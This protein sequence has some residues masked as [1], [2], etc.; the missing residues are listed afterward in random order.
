MA[1]IRLA[2]NNCDFA[3]RK[4]LATIGKGRKVATFLKRQTIFTQGDAAGAVFYIQKGKVRHTVVSE[5]G[6]E[7]TL[8]ILS[9][10]EFFGDDSLAGQPLRMGSATAMTDG[11]LL[12]I[13]KEAM[14]L[15]LHTRRAFS[16]LFVAYLLARN[17]RYQEDLVDQLFGSNEKRLARV[18]LLLANFGKDGTREAFMQKVSHETLADRAGL[19]RPRVSFFHE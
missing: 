7:A 3:P 9:E 19:T 11:K 16:D 5:F 14:M 15:A 6:K 8:R 18:L 4:F 1:R 10:G 12:Q 17:I 2:K 13:S